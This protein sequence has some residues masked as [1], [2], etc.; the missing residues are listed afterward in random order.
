[1]FPVSVESLSDLLIRDSEAALLRASERYHLSGFAY[2]FEVGQAHPCFYLA[3]DTGP[4]PCHASTGEWTHPAGGFEGAQMSDDWNRYY[5][6]L[7]AYMTEDDAHESRINEV[8]AFFRSVMKRI[9]AR[10]APRL[11]QCAFTVNETA[12]SDAVV[13]ATYTE[14]NERL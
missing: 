9:R 4:S 2:V 1:M 10:W 7:D 8:H 5:A 14:I 12:D 6:L 13:E 11:P 3:I